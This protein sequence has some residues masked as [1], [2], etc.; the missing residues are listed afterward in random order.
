[1]QDVR[2]VGQREGVG[3][4]VG[5]RVEMDGAREALVGEVAPG[6]DCV[7]GYGEGEVEGCS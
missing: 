5:A 7:G 1:M 6:A 4:A 3:R 2:S